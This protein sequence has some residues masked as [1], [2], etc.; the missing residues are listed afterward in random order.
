MKL[1]INCLPFERSYESSYAAFFEKNIINKV[2]TQFL[3]FMNYFS[4]I[5]KWS[6]ANVCII[7]I[8]FQADINC[9]N[10]L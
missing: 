1:R 10:L 4:F 5:H 9:S 8:H 6:G 3:H 7:R 2:S